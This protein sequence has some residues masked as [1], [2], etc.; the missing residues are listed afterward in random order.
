MMRG[1]ICLCL[2]AATAAGCGGGYIMTATDHVAPAGADAPFVVRLQRR[3]VGPVRMSVRRGALDFRL[4]EDVIRHGF[5]DEIGY[6]GVVLPAPET[7]GVYSVSVIHRDIEGDVGRDE[8]MLYVW[9]RDAGVVAVDYDS[10]PRAR[11]Q[12]AGATE[13]LGKLSE[14]ARILYMTREGPAEHGAIHERLARDGFPSGPVLLWQRKRWHIVHIGELRWPKVVIEDRLVS[15]LDELRRVFPGLR[16][17]V[18]AG[19]LAARAFAEAGLTCYAPEPL[20]SPSDDVRYV[21]S[22]THL[23]AIDP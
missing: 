16:T 14:K 2:L 20:D 21:K 5:T 11:S 10:L 23:D 7:P 18:C 12:V 22:W 1:T 19:S 17:A 6:A 4:G 15:Q 13:A 3:E 9:P 8:A